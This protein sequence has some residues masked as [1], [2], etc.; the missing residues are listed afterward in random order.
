M[1][2]FGDEIQSLWMMIHMELGMGTAKLSYEALR[3]VG[4]AAL[5][6]QPYTYSSEH[7][8]AVPGK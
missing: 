4:P 7:G 3:K 6:R 8:L 5:A 2:M 1:S